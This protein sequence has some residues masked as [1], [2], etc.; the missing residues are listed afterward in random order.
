MIG[1]ALS[2]SSIYV[3]LHPIKRRWFS[4]VLWFC[5]SR[6][7]TP[8]LPFQSNFFSRLI[9]IHFFIYIPKHCGIHLHPHDM[10]HTLFF[11]FFLH[12]GCNKRLSD[13]AVFEAPSIRRKHSR[14]YAGV[15]WLQCCSSENDVSLQH[16][17][18]LSALLSHT[19]TH[20]KLYY[21]TLM[22]LP[23]LHSYDSWRWT[24]TYRNTR[25]DSGDLFPLLY[26]C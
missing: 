21:I 23:C 15:M 26:T 18:W 16:C 11:F 4:P 6:V 20:G 13:W 5:S 22:P 12:S 17:N 14:W 7:V 25:L 1:L 19:Y 2:H 3:N 24:W 10:E 9:R 8:H